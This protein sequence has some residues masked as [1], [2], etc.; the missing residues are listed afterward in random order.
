MTSQGAVPAP[1][2]VFING[3]QVRERYGGVSDMWIV[4]R[5][6]GDP[7]FPRPLLLG[8]RRFWRVTDLEAWEQARLADG[9][10]GRSAPR[11]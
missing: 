8:G 2:F 1:G 9:I 10:V 11:R 5:L 3:R 6:A 7:E 4:R